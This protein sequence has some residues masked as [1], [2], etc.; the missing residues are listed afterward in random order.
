MNSISDLILA[1]FVIAF[2]GG[3]VLRLVTFQLA[4]LVYRRLELRR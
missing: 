1:A 2:F 3:F 4:G